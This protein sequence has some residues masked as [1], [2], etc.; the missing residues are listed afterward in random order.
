[1]IW[2]GTRRK[3]AQETV[4]QDKIEGE[5]V[6]KGTD[7]GMYFP[8]FST[9][10]RVELSRPDLRVSTQSEFSPANDKVKRLKRSVSIYV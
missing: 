1:M 4:S 7:D 6:A 5:L 10:K 9:N 3:D 8:L 2:K